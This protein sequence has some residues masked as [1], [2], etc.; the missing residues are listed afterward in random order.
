M[1][2]YFCSIGIGGSGIDGAIFSNF[3]GTLLSSIGKC[4][5]IT[6]GKLRLFSSMIISYNM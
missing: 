5:V 1:I 2:Y 3:E 6:V 4:G